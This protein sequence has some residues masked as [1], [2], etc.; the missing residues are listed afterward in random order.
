MNK[1]LPINPYGDLHK[2]KRGDAQLGGPRS[3][4]RAICTAPRTS[5]RPC[6]LL[7]LARSAA[8]IARSSLTE[9]NCAAVALG[10]HPRLGQLRCAMAPSAPNSPHST[11]TLHFPPADLGPKPAKVP[12]APIYSVLWGARLRASA[13]LMRAVRSGSGDRKPSS[14]RF[15]LT[16][17][18]CEIRANVVT[19]NGK[20]P[21]SSAPMVCTCT[22]DSSDKH[23]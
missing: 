16:S 14:N 3:D 13:F 6:P 23:S 1:A 4:Q 19:A 18:N 9:L 5:G 8:Q 11:P 12:S 15:G 21:C 17:K 2:V 7:D 20:L 10:F 22:P